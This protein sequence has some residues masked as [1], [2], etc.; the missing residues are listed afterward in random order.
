L[1]GTNV[2]LIE[3]VDGQEALQKIRDRH[4]DLILLDLFMPRLDGFGVL[5]AIK[6]NPV[7]KHIPI[8]VLSA[9]PTGDNRERAKKAGALDFIAK[10]YK[11]T[12]LAKLV[13][14]FL[15]TQTESG[16]VVPKPDTA[17]PD[18]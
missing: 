15:A 2:T 17:P 6:S 12:E 14:E 8:I 7:T 3:A 18:A 9:W 10:P 1:K 11:P 13:K 5:K 16:A 4:P